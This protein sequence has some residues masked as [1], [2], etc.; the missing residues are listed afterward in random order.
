MIVFVTLTYTCCVFGVVFGKMGRSPFWGFIFLPPYFGV[1]ALWITGLGR[2]PQERGR[3]RPREYAVRCALMASRYH[4]DPMTDPTNR[5]RED[6]LADLEA[7][8]AE[9]DAGFTIPGDVVRPD[10]LDSLARIS[11]Q[12]QPET[13]TRST[14]RIARGYSRA[15]RCVR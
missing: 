9:V 12:T 7:S 4:I 11:V 2:W 6:M 8:D 15:R 13:T 10:L 5:T 14:V 1:I 3:S